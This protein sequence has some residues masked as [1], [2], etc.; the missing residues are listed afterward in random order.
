MGGE[1]FPLRRASPASSASP[2][3]QPPGGAAP[4]ADPGGGGWEV[5]GGAGLPASP[6]SW[7]AKR[8]SAWPVSTC[9]SLS[10][11]CRSR[12][13]TRSCSSSTVPW[14]R[15]FSSKVALRRCS[16][17]RFRSDSILIC[18]G[19]AGVGVGV[20]SYTQAEASKRG[21][22]SLQACT[23]SAQG[24]GP[25]PLRWQLRT[26]PVEKPGKGWEWS[27]GKAGMWGARRRKGWVVLWNFHR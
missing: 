24:P 20:W 12:I 17:S 21:G 18:K 23:P 7:A 4:P 14:S 9:R 19:R 25:P 22:T 13:S 6:S 27:F 16:S 3:L 15:S 8:C 1:A 26:P 5:G 11:P 10:W 2:E